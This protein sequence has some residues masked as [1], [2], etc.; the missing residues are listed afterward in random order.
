[1]RNID[2]QI[3]QIK[4]KQDTEFT[5]KHEEHKGISL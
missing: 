5:K 3:S 4:R 2:P 1:M